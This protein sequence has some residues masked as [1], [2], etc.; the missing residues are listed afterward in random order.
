MEF[1]VTDQNQSIPPPQDFLTVNELAKQLSVEVCTI[2]SYVFKMLIPVYRLPFSSTNYFILDE[3][4]KALGLIPA[5]PAT[6]NF[7]RKGNFLKKPSSQTLI[8]TTELADLLKIKVSTVY[9]WVHK[10][11]ITPCK[12]PGSSKNYFVKE[13]VV[14]LILN[15][16]SKTK[17]ELEI[18][19]QTRMLKMKKIA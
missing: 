5:N 2:Y 4:K 1:S 16:R 8:T 14:E 13:E 15:N 3:V 6:I 11:L 17:S 10:Q 7:N 9:S 12:Y 19:A 18:E